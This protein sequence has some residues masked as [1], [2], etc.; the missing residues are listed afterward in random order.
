MATKKIK[1][2]FGMNDFL[3]GGIQRQFVEMVK[4]ID[5]TKFDVVLV[6]LLEFP[7]EP[8][9]YAEIPD[10]VEVQ[11][12]NFKGFF[13]VSS[14]RKLYGFLKDYRPD[15]VV[16][17]IFFSN[18]IFR[19]LKPLV[20]FRSIVSEQNTYTDK[21]LLSRAIDSILARITYRIV[22]SSK[23]VAAFTSKN[24]WIPETKFTVIHNGVPVERLM[25]ECAALPEKNVLKTQ[26]G[27]KESDKIV[28]N[29]ARLMPQKNHELLFRG[30]AEFSRLHPEYI[31]AVVGPG[32]LRQKLEALIVELGMS[33]RIRLL[34]PQNPIVP[35]YAVSDFFVLTSR[36]EG[37]ALVGVEAM[38]CGLPVVSTRTAGPDE[39]IEEG[40]NGFFIDKETPAG[41]AAAL[42]SVVDGNC[43]ELR[44]GAVSMAT[45]FAIEKAVS[46]YSL[47]IKECVH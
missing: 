47:L 14:W 19:V 23:S 43:E 40:K 24:E 33:D 16:S 29:V 32:P 2:V 38:A 42:K 1:V 39:Y 15:V 41:V 13:D 27:F 18:T 25:K 36:I 34:G 17:S 5:R 30:F 44:A 7:E 35:Y 21:S 10:D 3:I 6:T 22:A 26:L 45:E 11:R 20:R 8:T 28:I 31:L 37:F 9:L 46:K 4:C 12:F